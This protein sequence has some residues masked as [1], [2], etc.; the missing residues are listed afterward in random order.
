MSVVAGVK[1][2][3][4]GLEVPKY[5][6]GSRTARGVWSTVSASR[7]TL[8]SYLW[9]AFCLLFSFVGPLIYHT[10]QVLTNLSDVNSAPTLHHLLGTDEV[11]YDQLGRLMV[12]G[13]VTLAVGVASALLATLLGSVWGGIA[14]AIG[15]VVDSIMMRLVDA[16]LAIP[17]LFLILFL[18]SVVVPS[19]GLLI[20]V[21]ALTS[22]LYPARLVRGEALALRHQ[23][24]VEA[25][26][27][28]GAR[29]P[30]II[31][32][33]ILPNSVGVI[34]VSAALQAA[35]AVLLFSYLSFL[36][37]GIPP[38]S[39]DWGNML[40]T[41]VTFALDGEWWLLWPPGLLIISVVVALTFIG[42]SVQAQ[43]DA[44]RRRR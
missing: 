27:S 11:G 12:G 36:G 22:W 16:L 4:P 28:M 13:Q 40:S 15:G 33:H 23:E 39:A 31:V 30:W 35:N 38:P 14:G 3:E 20:F 32:R 24:F 37:L 44:R 41:G 1:V 6:R 29:P 9:V 10:Q 42:D 21:I 25:A 43:V 2:E 5:G 8:V 17:A 26:R 19:E 34:A 7:L 18:S